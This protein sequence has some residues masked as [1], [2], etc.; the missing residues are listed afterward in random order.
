[1]LDFSFT[2]KLKKMWNN[3][4]LSDPVLLQIAEKLMEN[5]NTVPSSNLDAGMTYFGQMIAHDI[6][7]HTT[8]PEH[9]VRTISNELLLDSL[10]GHNH[11]I[12]NDRFEM[13][14]IQW[15]GVKGFDVAR[16]ENG[17]ALIPDHRNDINDIVC[18][19]HCFWQNFHNQ[20]IEA[21]YHFDFENAKCHTIL[22]FQFVT[23]EYFLK[24]LLEPHI[25]D[26]YF[27][28]QQKPKL[29]FKPEQRLDY[30]HNSAFRFGHS[31]VRNSYALRRFHPEVPLTSL[32]TS[33]QNIK[34]KHVIQ[35]HRF[36]GD[37]QKANKIDLSL[38]DAMSRIRFPSDNSEMIRII[39]KNLLAGLNKQIPSGYNL[40]KKINS[41]TKLNEVFQL[42]PV[43]Q[44]P[45][46]FEGIEELNIQ[47]LPLWTYV[48][49]EAA[50]TQNGERLGKLGS[51]L[52]ADV[53]HDAINTEALSIFK[54]G[55]YD[56]SHALN[57]L[58]EVK[59]KLLD[60]HNNVDLQKLFTVN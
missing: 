51:I 20:L 29:P 13:R 14:P 58:S 24:N 25:F 41:D 46:E 42:S 5:N 59:D 60:E 54:N 23:I 11:R 47:N 56:K 3:N 50:T 52:I 9:P 17:R 22:S 44:L 6:A 45:K 57:V 30:F 31:M 16:D 43:S 40:V 18:Q 39:F 4:Y 48:L 15:Q 33:S 26:V 21:P 19:L 2:H 12:V 38:S 35:W 1:M 49:H 10:Y 53:L 27:N 32:F 34:D 8:A 55:T 37:N 7:P 36:F 28:Q